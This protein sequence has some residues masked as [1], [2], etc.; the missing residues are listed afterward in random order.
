MHQERHKHASCNVINVRYIENIGSKGRC[1]NGR[2]Q[3]FINLAIV[4]YICVYD[5][6][7]IDSFILRGISPRSFIYYED[8]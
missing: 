8:H 7:L 4:K 3:I 6:K 1:N 2:K 5:V